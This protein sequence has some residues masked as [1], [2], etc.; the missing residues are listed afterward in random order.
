MLASAAMLILEV[1]FAMSPFKSSFF[2]VVFSVCSLHHAFPVASSVAPR[3]ICH[4]VPD[5]ALD[6]GK[7]IVTE[8]PPWRIAA[9]MR[10][11]SCAKLAE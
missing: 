4:H 1:N 9:V 8:R 3:S 7:T 2:A 10:A 11:A 5:E 6:L